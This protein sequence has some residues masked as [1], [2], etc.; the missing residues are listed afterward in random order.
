MSAILRYLCYKS[1]SQVQHEFR[2][3]AATVVAVVAVVIVV[4][5]TFPATRKNARLLPFGTRRV[6][7]AAPKVKLANLTLRFFWPTSKVK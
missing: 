2:P 4:A 7:P 6:Q 3:H 5:A 1:V